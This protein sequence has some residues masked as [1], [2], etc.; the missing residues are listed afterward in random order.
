MS[1][2][3]APLLAIGLAASFAAA[4]RGATTPLRSVAR[5]LSTPPASSLPAGCSLGRAPAG[6]RVLVYSRTTGY[7]HASIPAAAAAI[8]SLGA[9]HGFE[10]EHT[11]DPTQFSDANLARFAAVVFLSN[12]QKVLDST[13]RAAFQRYIRAGHGYVGIHASSNAEIDWPWYGELM[14]AFFRQHPKVQAGLV[15]V[16]DATHPSTKCLPARWNRPDEWYN[17]KT[18]PVASARILLTVDEKSYE[19]G[20]MGD[21]HPLAWYHEF[22]GGRAWYTALG[23]YDEHYTDPVYRSHIVGGILWAIGVR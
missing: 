21:P 10:V 3:L 17:F 12:T 1:P 23:H 2:R 20:T 7:R 9:E 15:L 4:C 13:Q 19:G 22:D 16:Q 8:R 14:G 18:P 6:S 11:E 5:Q